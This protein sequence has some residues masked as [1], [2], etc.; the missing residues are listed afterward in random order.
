M[1]VTSRRSRR[2]VFRLSVL[3]ILLHL[4]TT[5]SQLCNIPL[6]GIF[7]MRRSPAGL[8]R[9]L[10]A[11]AAF[12]D[13][14]PG[15]RPGITE[16]N[17]LDP[18]DT[19]SYQ[20][21]GS[22][23]AVG[24]NVTYHL[25]SESTQTA[26]T[27][28]NR[29]I[30]E[31]IEGVMRRF[32]AAILGPNSSSSCKAINSVSQIFSVPYV[33]YAATSTELSD[34]S[35][36]PHFF[37][38][39]PPDSSQA[40]AIVALISMAGWDRIGVMNTRD[41]YG[42]TGASALITEASNAGVTTV[43]QQELFAGETDMDSIIALVKRVKSSGVRIIVIFMLEQAAANVLRA[44][45]TSN[46][47]G[48]GW[49]WISSDGFTGTD[50]SLYNL[51]PASKGFLGI[52]Q[53]TKYTNNQHFI[54]FNQSW[55]TTVNIPGNIVTNFKNRTRSYQ[56]LPIGA[57]P[58]SYSSYGNELNTYAPFAYDGMML[59][60]NA[61]RKLASGGTTPCTLNDLMAYRQQLTAILQNQTLD[62]TT[63]RITFDQNQDRLFAGYD[64]RNH[65]GDSWNDIA[66]WDRIGGFQFLPGYN[67]RNSPVWS[68]GLA[69]FLNAP[70]A[71]VFDAFPKGDDD[72]EVY[73]YTILALIPIIAGG[74]YY[75]MKR[76]GDDWAEFLNN[77]MGDVLGIIL[78]VLLNLI[79]FATDALSYLYVLQTPSLQNFVIPYTVF[80]ILAGISIITHTVMASRWLWS[81]T[82][83]EEGKYAVA[84]ELAERLEAIAKRI[85]NKSTKRHVDIYQIDG[86]LVRI[87][88]KKQLQFMLHKGFHGIRMSLVSICTAVFEDFPFMVMNAMIL[89]QDGEVNVAL[90]ASF[91]FNCYICGTMPSIYHELVLNLNTSRTLLV[92]IAKMREQ[93][94]RTN[95]QSSFAQQKQ[96]YDGDSDK[97][98]SG[99]M[100]ARNPRNSSGRVVPTSKSNPYPIFRQRS[101]S[102]QLLRQLSAACNDKKTKGHHIDSN[103]KLTTNPNENDKKTKGHH[104]NSN[105]K[106]TTNPNENDNDNQNNQITRSFKKVHILRK[107]G[108]M[109]SSSMTKSSDN[110]SAKYVQT[111]PMHAA[112]DQITPIPEIEEN[113]AQATA[114]PTTSGNKSISNIFTSH[115]TKS[116]DQAVE[117][118][119]IISKRHDG[120]DHP[121]ENV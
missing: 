11:R 65:D 62:G 37:R 77:I 9:E 69:G 2:W 87:K 115:V 3:V 105:H 46:M 42:S 61:I 71:V 74:F 112:P 110:I 16:F 18:S 99:S 108:S 50:F 55:A 17:N 47:V 120:R 45:V 54:R 41:T 64:I 75:L 32:V 88:N 40:A 101:S 44:A 107:Q 92:A 25:F 119:T 14:F 102:T 23:V 27:D 84:E 95:T 104:I 36:Y 57:M 103:H 33:S 67:S 109:N 35:I 93:K 97:E 96:G 8:Q 70:A 63:G 73:F 78:D 106:L 38:V 49:V 52:T 24:I 19:S 22:D 86:S 111:K 5:V 43:T 30:K 34:V 60:L 114:Q 10:A 7:Q 80:M 117:L 48:P 31:T 121:E 15:C 82:C 85:T 90:L 51:E 56:N 81:L 29:A 79:D 91:A 72:S 113:L 4:E 39:C 76:K 28:D 83:K 59:L 13:F 100:S 6:A 89:V 116:R 26:N 66:Q 58:T 68:D 118:S 98:F 53:A 20:L 21:W 1:R 94:S 12:C